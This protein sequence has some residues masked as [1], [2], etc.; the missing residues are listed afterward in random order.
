MAFS[1]KDLAAAASANT[2]IDAL[3]AEVL[4]TGV[5][6]GTPAP[7][8]S[9]SIA[10]PT[11]TRIYQ[12]DTRTGGLFGK[13]AGAV[14][15]SVTVSAPVTTLDFRLRDA[16]AAGNP[17]R[18]DWTPLG[19]P[20]LAGT[21]ALIPT[22][23]ASPYRY[24]FDV[25]AN[26]DTTHAALGTQPFGVG[27]VVAVAGQSLATNMLVAGWSP[28]GTISSS[29]ISLA[30]NGYEFAPSMKTE[31]G[32][33]PYV[34]PSL[35]QWATPADGTA[36]G[37][38]FAA[39]FLRLVTGQ[40]GV[41][42]AL[43]GFTYGGSSITTWQPGQ[44]NYATLRATLDQVGRVGAL[45]WMQG[46]SD[47]QNGMGAATY[48]GLL[49]SLFNDLAAHYAGPGGALGA[50]PR[51][52]CS[53]PALNTTFWGTPAQVQAIRSGALAYVASDAR[54]RYVAALDMGISSDG[55]HPNQ[56][57]RVPT[58]RAFYRAFMGLIGL[59]A[60]KP[61]PSLAGA[62]RTVGSAVVKLAVTPSAGG[63][64]LAAVGTPANQFTVYPAGTLTG[65]LA[66]SSLSI[67]S[68]TE[69]DLMLA[70]VPADTQALDVWYRLA[71]AD[72]AAITG[73]GIYDNATDG[74]GLATGR[75]LQL[76]P[77]AITAAAP[78]SAANA[79]PLMFG[80]AAGPLTGLQVLT[81]LP[82]ADLTGVGRDGAGTLSLPSNDYQAGVFLNAGT[83][84]DGIADTEFVSGAGGAGVILF[85][86]SADMSS[87]YRLTYLNIDIALEKCVGGT[88][89]LVNHLTGQPSIVG[90]SALGVRFAGS[91]FTVRVGKVD[92]AAEFTDT[93]IPANGCLGLGKANQNG[94]LVHQVS[95]V[96]SD[97]ILTG[98]PA[99]I[100]A[101][102]PLS[103][104][105]Y[106]PTQATPTYFVLFNVTT[107]AEEGLR[108][109]NGVMRSKLD[110]L[111][112]QTS[113]TYTVRGFAAASGGSPTYES[114]QI[115]VTAAPGA[116]P[117]T[118]AQA[119]DTNRTSSGVTMSW[120]ATV[121]SY[122]VLAR[123]GPGFAYGSLA[124]ATVTTNSYT[125]AGLAANSSPRA[126]VIPQN[127]S[128]YGTPTGQ[129]LSS[130]TA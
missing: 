34:A 128:G 67:V 108:W 31:D 32:N 43:V 33:A 81:P 2:K 3:R 9:L 65:A 59:A 124:D 116:L 74:D 102:Q 53:I 14:A 48:Q 50:F 44:A 68:A 70:A 80:G 89:S 77:A 92:T 79:Y 93:S 12:R 115:A 105:T 72:T 106:T 58:A 71:D 85:R 1:T 57:G 30:A 39:E 54:A 121:A 38:A 119:A 126:V 64:A 123:S 24:L 111:I 21:A 78:V 4:A 23:P 130:T 61:G 118:P 66:I 41:M 10:Q 46:H 91:T 28:E 113:A 25:R 101:G 73:S 86:A 60:D 127:A 62:T 97:S 112:P 103:A 6:N 19:G 29:G 45:I 55:T 122:H 36:Y 100:V 5:L 42:S 95:F 16:D 129:F 26:G 75:Q 114:A 37:S 98:L 110:L 49:A 7:P 40:A 117:A 83:V 27:E 18:Q 107:G 63:T 51:L 125:F 56:A 84:S 69:I 11:A 17:V 20:L 109:Q 8:L 94:V 35:T 13:G 96:A 87:Y 99:T 47:A 22:V 90:A 76:A 120:S 52:I 88:T 82:G 104:A 15:V